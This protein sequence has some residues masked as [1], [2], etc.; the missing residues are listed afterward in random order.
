MVDAVTSQTLLDN[1]TRLIMK[2]TNISD[3]T[4]ESAVTKVTAS[5]FSCDEL[6]IER[7]HFMTHGMGAD[8]LFDATT[9]VVAMSIPVNATMSYDFSSFGGIKNNAGA[10]KTGNIKVT[11]YDFSSGDRYTII[12]EMRKVGSY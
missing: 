9:P 1:K 5:T 8:I 12:L 3:G 7:V 11:T 2:F 6:Y 4:G 10:G